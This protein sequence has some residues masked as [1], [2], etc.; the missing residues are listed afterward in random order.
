MKTLLLLL[1]FP[2][3]AFAQTVHYLN[4]PPVAG[5]A[6]FGAVYV[7]GFDSAGN[8]RGLCHYNQPGNRYGGSF[9]ADCRWDVL[10][11]PLSATPCVPA[12]VPACPVFRFTYHSLTVNGITVDVQAIDAQGNIAAE[13]YWPRNA[14]LVIP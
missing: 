9:Y 6:P 8:M 4:A 14:V 3:S 12:G 11:N 10:G 7:T 2:V 5:Y 13:E 1:L